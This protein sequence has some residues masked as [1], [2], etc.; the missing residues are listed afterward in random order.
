MFY[1]SLVYYIE[2]HRTPEG[3]GNDFLFGDYVPP[4]IEKH[5]TPEGDGNFYQILC[6]L[7]G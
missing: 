6:D 5:R 7:R 3:D 1:T 2:K 4:H